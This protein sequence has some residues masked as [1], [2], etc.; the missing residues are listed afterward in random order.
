MH[1]D[2][3]LDLDD[4]FD[5]DQ[6]EDC[7]EDDHGDE[8]HGDD[9]HGNDDHGDD[10]CVKVGKSYRRWIDLKAADKGTLA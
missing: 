8:Y 10:H 4:D 9:G 5:L 3:G 6:Q 1:S 7:E 2:L